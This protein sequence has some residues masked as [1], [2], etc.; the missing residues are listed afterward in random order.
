MSLKKLLLEQE[1]IEQYK[2]LNDASAAQGISE[3]D[4]GQTKIW[5]LKSDFSRDY[6]MGIDFITNQLGLELPTAKTIEDTHTLLGSIR[7]TDL[8]KIFHMLQGE[9]WSPHGEARNVISDLGLW[10]T[11]MSVG[12]IIEVDGNLFFVDRFGF[13]KLVNGEV[14]ESIERKQ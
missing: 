2:T 10:H 14:K 7:E 9:V 11:S 8:D 4:Q 5:Y 1:D 3:L 13:K 6:M 12:D